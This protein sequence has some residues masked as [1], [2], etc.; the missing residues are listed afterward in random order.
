M[1]DDW[2]FPAAGDV[3]VHPGGAGLLDNLKFV[4]YMNQGVTINIG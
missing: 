1:S 2:L 3:L 4:L